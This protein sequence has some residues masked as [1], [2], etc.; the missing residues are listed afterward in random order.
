MTNIEFS[1]IVP[2]FNS[3]K[4]LPELFQR[5]DAAFIKI[6]KYYEVIFIDDGSSDNSWDI[7][8]E[9]KNKYTEKITA[10]KL[11]KNFGQHNAIL[12][13]LKFVKGKYAVT[14]DD[15]L[16]QRPE[17]IEAMYEMIIA[18]NADIVY[19]IYEEKKHSLSRRIGS[20]YMNKSSGFSR[21]VI[22]GASFRLIR[23]E[24][25]LKMLEGTHDLVYIDEILSW[26]TENVAFTNV[27]HEPRKY[28]RSNYTRKK[29]LNHAFNITLFYT[30]FPLRLMTYGGMFSSLI[31]F[32]I[33]LFF[34]LKKFFHKVPM[35]YTSLIVAILFTAS[36]ILMCMGILGEYLFRIYKSQNR[37][38]PYAISKIL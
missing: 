35:G 37:R 17:D 26:Y 4:S 7:V 16:Q 15:D 36:L 31:F 29:L 1:V 9:L 28:G 11:L 6:N 30:A 25:V 22:A 14:I 18:S 32:M 38:P 2:V 23:S 34:L 12:C 3:E 10:I 21:K 33:G 27:K 5:I 24:I 8:T 19:G 20:W 13:G